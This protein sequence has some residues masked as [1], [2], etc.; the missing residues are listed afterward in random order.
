[1]E[2]SGNAHSRA[3]SAIPM[4]QEISVKRGEIFNFVRFLVDDFETTS[5]FS[6]LSG[7][8]VRVAVID[9]GCTLH[10]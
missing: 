9:S 8:R 1:M 6:G 10:L 3:P 2:V 4:Y 7:S 5:Y